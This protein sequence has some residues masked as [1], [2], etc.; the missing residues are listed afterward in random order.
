MFEWIRH[1]RYSKQYYFETYFRRQDCRV[2]GK[3]GIILADL[4]M[5]EDYQVDFYT[6]FMDHVFDYSL[7][8]FLHPIV[9]ADRGKALVFRQ[10]DP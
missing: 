8:A 9:L 7:P 5:P 6:R 3:P 1:W 4:G 10:A 2:E